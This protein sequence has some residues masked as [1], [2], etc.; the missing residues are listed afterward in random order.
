[1]FDYSKVQEEIDERNERI[2]LNG[3]NTAKKKVAEPVKPANP[4]ENKPSQQELI[5]EE[6]KARKTDPLLAQRVEEGTMHLAR[7][8]EGFF[9]RTPLEKWAEEESE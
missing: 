3:Q 6:R 8:R 4:T 1:M 7:K 2:A 5:E 9:D